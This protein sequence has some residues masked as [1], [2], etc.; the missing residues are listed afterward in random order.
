MEGKVLQISAGR[1]R[2]KRLD[3][4]PPLVHNVFMVQTCKQVLLKVQ[5]S[6]DLKKKL[7]VFAAQNSKTMNQVVEEAVREHC[8]EKSWPAGE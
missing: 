1:T 2:E 7:K 4:Y 3:R 6:A 5:V 8:V